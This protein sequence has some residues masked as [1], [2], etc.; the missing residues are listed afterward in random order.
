MTLATSFAALSVCSIVALATGCS[1]AGATD[2]ASSN[3]D[4]TEALSTASYSPSTAVAYAVSHWSDGVGECA[5]FVYD[6]LSAGHLSIGATAWVPT[7][8]SELASVDYEE[9]TG[10][11]EASAEA[12]DVVVFSTASGSAFCGPGPVNGVACGHTCFVTVGGSSPSSIKV[13]CHNTAH[14][15]IAVSAFFGEYP[16]F[17]VYHTAAG[18]S[19]SG[20]SGTGG[21]SGS[22]C[23][24][25]TLGENVADN[26]CV[27]ESSG[28]WFQCDNG[29]WVPRA[30]DPTA[31]S[32]VTPY[33]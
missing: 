23:Y 13:D 12:G 18:A 16:H 25:N 9:H 15:E 1:S 10:N 6:C 14:H 26:A 2:A 20:G 29:S 30:S 31:C 21:T 22:G 11:V 32:S 27:E 33:N 7:L 17:R 24:S 5:E 4:S 28:S 8:V 19:G 3:S